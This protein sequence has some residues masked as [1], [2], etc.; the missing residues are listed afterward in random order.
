[1][2]KILTTLLMATF[3]TSM[4]GTSFAKQQCGKPNISKQVTFVNKGLAKAI[5]NLLFS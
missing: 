1:M 3:L 5:E 2:K 4:I